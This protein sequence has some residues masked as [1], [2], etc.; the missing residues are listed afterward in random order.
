MKTLHFSIVIEAP[1]EKVWHAMLDEKP[2]REWTSAFGAGGYYKG[3][4]EKGSK[5]LFLGPDPGTGELG[6]MVSRIA[7]NIPY[8]YI[9]IEHQGIMKDGVEDTSSEEAR[10]WTPAFENYTFREKDGGTELLVHADAVDEFVP[11]FTEQ[12]PI[13]LEKLKQIA[14]RG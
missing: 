13:A 2:Y 4:W 1:R 5:I 9:S 7:E 8:E 10:K 12:W 3:N 14:E 11:M 6:G